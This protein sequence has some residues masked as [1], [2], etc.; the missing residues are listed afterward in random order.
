VERA[1]LILDLL[2]TAGGDLSLKELALRAELPKASVFRMLRTLE[3]TG[4]VERPFG[5]DVYRLGVRCLTLGQAYLEQTNLRDEARPVLEK[6]RSQF[7]ETVHLAVLDD[8][9]RVVY[10][11]KLETPHA[12]GLMMSRIGR[13]VPAF[14]TGIGKALLAGLN[15]DPVS[16][17]ERR[18]ILRRYTP[19]TIYDP[20]ALRRELEAC[21][22]SGYALDL[23]EHE[24]GVSCVGCPITGPR[25]DVVAAISIAG[26]S[27]RLP[28][29][30]LQGE[31]A[32]ATLRA[33]REISHRLGGA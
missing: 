27:Q 18:G 24:P 20:E 32:D 22:G 10:L 12:V 3:R 11:E 9:L 15:G 21:R 7:D 4:L 31:L 5:Q 30:L 8:E 6:L 23:E 1:A 19:S 33:A 16:E 14:C 28:K 25:G 13:T 17:L 26:P 2:Y 29:R